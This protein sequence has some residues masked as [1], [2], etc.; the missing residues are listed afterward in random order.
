[1][2]SNTIVKDKSIF[3]MAQYELAMLTVNKADTEAVKE[4]IEKLSGKIVKEEVWEKRQLAYP[5][6]HND[7]GTYVFWN[8]EIDKKN[9]SELRKRLQ[10]NDVLLRFLLLTIEETK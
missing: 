6:R 10:F 7:T 8:I 4:Y 3:V 9:V 2:T 5:I 1:M